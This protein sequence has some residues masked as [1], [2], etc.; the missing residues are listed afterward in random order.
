[1]YQAGDTQIL[2][3]YQEKK[4]LQ[5]I[6]LAE[7]TYVYG[8]ERVIEI[9]GFTSRPDIFELAHGFSGII[10]LTADNIDS[11]SSMPAERRLQLDQVGIDFPGIKWLFD[12]KYYTEARSEPR[13]Q[14]IGSTQT[15]VFKTGATYK[16]IIGAIFVHPQ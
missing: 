13:M 8:N 16:K 10:T 4:Q 5:D 12:N 15:A 1:M 2:L 3:G 9:L 11:F 14:P 7:T 6:Y